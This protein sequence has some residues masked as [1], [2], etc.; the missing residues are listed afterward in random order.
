MAVEGR[1]PETDLKWNLIAIAEEGGLVPKPLTGWMTW[2]DQDNKT[3]E[4]HLNIK[5][6]VAA[7]LLCNAHSLFSK[8]GNVR[9]VIINKLKMHPT[10]VPTFKKRGGR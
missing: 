2:L 8:N 6:K 10:G 7:L 3:E 9:N 1:R 5:K 4:D